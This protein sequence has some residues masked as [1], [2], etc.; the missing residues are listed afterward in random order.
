MKKVILYTVDG[1]F[2]V[3]GRVPFFNVPPD[4]LIWVDRVFR[5]DST[6]DESVDTYIECFAVALIRVD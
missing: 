3:S 4:V 2:V 6:D 5:Y 1:G